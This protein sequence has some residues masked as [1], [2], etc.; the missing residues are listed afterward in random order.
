MALDGIV[1]SNIAAELDARLTGARI[2]KIAQP[3]ADEL[4]LTLKSPN[5]GQVRL[6]LSAS[7]SLPL[8]YLTSVNKPSPVTAPAFCML[9]RKHVGGGKIMRIYQP[10]L[11]RILHFEIEHLNEM[12]DLCHKDLVLELMGKH[13]NLIFCDDDGTIIDS[14]KRVSAQTSSVREVLP[15]RPYFIAQTQEKLD[16]LSTTED[17]FCR[18]VFSK[19]MKLAKAIY[20]SYT[21]ISPVIAEELCHRA[22]LESDQSAN[23]IPEMEQLH[24]YHLF[25]LMMEDVK[26]H[27]YTPLIV[28]DSHGDPVEFS[29][30]PLTMYADM[31]VTEYPTISEVLEQYYARKN[32]VTRIRQKS[33]DL[34]HIT[35]TALERNRKKYELQLKQLKDTE[36]RDQYRVYGE[37]IHAYGY[38]IEA[39]AKSFDALNYYTNEMMTVP[40]DPTLTPQENAQRYFNKYNKLKRTYEALSELIEETKAEIDQLESICTFMDLALS[41]EDLVQVKEELTDAGYIRRRYNGKRVRITSHPYHYRSSDG[42]D[43]YVGKNN[44]QNDELTFKF[45]SGNDWWFHAKG[46]PGSHVIVKSRG[47]ELPDRTF[48][49]AARLAAYYSKNRDAE[50]VEIDYVEKKHVKK[51]NGAKPGFVVYY[52]NYSMMIDPDIRDLELVSD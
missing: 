3:E 35:V 8:I 18:S 12:G 22:S 2:A 28:N 11:E 21:G 45:A 24:L 39:G 14:I 6:L 34:R 29:S 50:K 43:L 10:G 20:S 42:F 5:S 44:Y 25:D 19:P 38:G 4:L 32:T 1:V 16:P 46:A 41:E 23:T 26:Q 7:A 27:R 13:S 47:E 31:Q 40:L 52:T 36:K 51:P 30:L 48:E 37:L 33:A 49:E 15:G 17:A 9:L